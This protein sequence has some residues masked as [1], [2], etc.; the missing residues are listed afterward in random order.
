MNE[1]KEIDVG[2]IEKSVSEL[3]KSMVVLRIDGS[4]TL[5][6]S[7]CD[8]IKEWLESID[9]IDALH[10]YIEKFEENLL[11]SSNGVNTYDDG[12]TCHLKKDGYFGMFAKRLH[13]AL[14]YLDFSS[15]G[16]L[17]EQIIA[18]KKYDIKVNLDV[19]YDEQVGSYD[20]Y[21]HKTWTTIT[22]IH[23]SH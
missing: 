14:H 15:L 4:V 20:I 9:S 19:G 1:I 3:M 16:K 18:Y 10:D 5:F 6:S 23:V 2:A 21:L 13:V 22:I 17:F 7:C 11:P 8:V 12:M